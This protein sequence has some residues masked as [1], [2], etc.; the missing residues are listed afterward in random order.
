M[1]VCQGPGGLM[2][3]CSVCMGAGVQAANW[4]QAS[5]S[6]RQRPGVLQVWWWAGREFF[7][8]PLELRRG[9]DAVLSLQCSGTA[10]LF[11]SSIAHPPLSTAASP[12]FT[13][14]HTPDHPLP[15][16]ACCP[17]IPLQ[18]PNSQGP[19]MVNAPSSSNLVR[20]NSAAEERFDPLAPPEQN[21][22]RW[23][24]GLA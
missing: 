19:G 10:L 5:T 21:Y 1:K 13:P 23:G 16:T 8:Q 7:T 24:L 11:V 4:A 22:L 6:P 9:V 2:K 18:A 12:L 17:F 14:P 20:S 3:Q 15:L